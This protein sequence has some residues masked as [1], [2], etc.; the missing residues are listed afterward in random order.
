MHEN[1]AEC[2]NT[3]CY[4]TGV[5]TVM[6]DLEL[7]MKDDAVLVSFITQILLYLELSI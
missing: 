7:H 1:S 5:I 6:S 4:F 3:L 2:L